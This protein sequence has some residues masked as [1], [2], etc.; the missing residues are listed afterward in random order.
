M[1]LK[2]QREFSVSEAYASVVY[3]VRPKLDLKSRMYL[4]DTGV[5][6][7]S[8]VWY[9]YMHPLRTGDLSFEVDVR[10]PLLGK[11]PGHFAQVSV[12]IHTISGASLSWIIDENGYEEPQTRA[13]NDTYVQDQASGDP[14]LPPS[15]TFQLREDP[16]P[17]SVEQRNSSG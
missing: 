16:P 15:K 11:A 17:I 1:K 13:V 5:D 8:P 7:V 9:K 3:A 12:S 2:A 10:S 6:V 4:G 14:K